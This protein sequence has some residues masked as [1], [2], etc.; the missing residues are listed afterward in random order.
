MRE[1]ASDFRGIGQTLTDKLAAIGPCWGDDESGHQFYEVYGGPRD[2][3]LVGFTDASDLV[4]QTADGIETMSKNYRT[5]E[6]QNIDHAQ[7][8]KGGGD[9][10]SIGGN[11]GGGHGSR[12]AKP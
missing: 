2:E 9:H 10:L 1:I 6:D 3:L 7:S 12:P 8:L 4:N 5:L 11:E